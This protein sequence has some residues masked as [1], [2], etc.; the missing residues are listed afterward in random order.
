MS[1][2]T[3]SAYLLRNERT[4]LYLTVRDAGEGAPADIVQEALQ[5]WPLR[6]GQA[7]RLEPGEGGEDTYGIRNQRSGRCLRARRRVGEPGAAVVRARPEESGPAYRSWLLANMDLHRFSHVHGGLWP[8]AGGAGE[9][10]AGGVVID[11][12]RERA[13]GDGAAQRWHF[14]PAGPRVARKTFDALAGLVVRPGPSRLVTAATR[15]RG[16]APEAGAGVF[17]AASKW[18]AVP[19]RTPYMRFDGFRG[20]EVVRF[21]QRNRIED[22]PR[23]IAERFPHLP[24]EFHGGFDFV[25]TTPCGSAHP[26]LGVKD[27]LAVEFSER[28]SR[29]L[30]PGRLLPGGGP[31]TGRPLKAVAAAPDGSRYLVFGECGTAVVGLS[32]GRYGR[33]VREAAL[34]HVPEDF[35]APDT[36]ASAAV[37]DE[38]HYFATKGD[39]YLVFTFREVIQGPAKILGAYPFLLDL[40][41]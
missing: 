22:G 14:E 18:A 24:E 16:R 26:Y 6:A 13:G 41:A 5:D 19:D 28:G 40:W 36:I 31:V 27:G 4:G 12:C 30:P 35:R 20:D 9:A 2:D 29:D 7:W 23:K 21:S 8:G 10:P 33:E 17:G 34:G 11:Q 3:R 32:G 37:G 1:V 15:G 38:M 25:T 39:R